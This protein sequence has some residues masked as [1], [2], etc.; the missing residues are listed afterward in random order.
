[1]T[2]HDLTHRGRRVEKQIEVDAPAERL[3]CA[4]SEPELL[5]G[6][7]ADRA[8]GGSAVGDVQTWHF[9]RFGFAIPYEVVVAEPN[10]RFMLRCEIPGKGVGLMEVLLEERGGRTVMR[11]V[12]SGFKEG[13]EWDAE[14]EGVNSGW[15]M[16]FAI[17]G[18]FVERHFGETRHDFLAMRPGEF[19]YADAVPMF[20]SAD[21]LA[22]WLTQSGELG[23]PGSDV[24]LVTRGG[25]TLTGRVLTHTAWESAMSCEELN[26]VLEFKAFQMGPGPKVVALR[27]SC[28]DRS[29]EF[30]ASFEEP[31]GNAL[32]G[33]VKEL[34][35]G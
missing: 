10:R 26:G 18:E 22:R 30:A 1:M 11:F 15:Q 12:N 28:W 9:D 2:T 21:G 14:Y 5:S 27:G 6:W 20:R 13:A 16:A 4:W 23:D 19:E 3:Y 35:A 29:P 7:F 24:Q 8:E 32:E 17:L 25:T 33:L 34:A 31:L